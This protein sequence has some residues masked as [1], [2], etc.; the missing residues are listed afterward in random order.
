MTTPD[1]DQLLEL[2][3][4]ARARAYAPYSGF[5]VGAAVLSGSGAV[6]LGCNVENSAYPAGICAE[7]GALAAAIAAGER[8]FVRMVVLAASDRPVPPCGMCRQVLAEVAPRVRLLLA[9]LAGVREETTPEALL[10]Y[11][12]TP[13]DLVSGEQRASRSGA[14]PAAGYHRLSS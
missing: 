14:L 11:A 6:Y 10:P 5:Q 7:R 1:D 13:D 4:T 3:A 2:A 9:N 8:Q 12:F